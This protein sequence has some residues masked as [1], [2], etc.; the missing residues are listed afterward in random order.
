MAVLV[1]LVLPGMSLTGSGGPLGQAA[2]GATLLVLVV[3]GLT[4]G[5]RLTV[6]IP[7][8]VVEG[9]SWRHVLSRSWSLVG[10]HWGHVLGPCSWPLWPSAWSAP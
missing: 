6:S 7:A 3:A 8:A 9:R 2:L 4:V 5:V 10:G 1:L